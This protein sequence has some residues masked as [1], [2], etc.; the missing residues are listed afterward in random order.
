M[1]CRSSGV[2]I[3]IPFTFKARKCDSRVPRF[4]GLSFG[5]QIMMC[6]TLPFSLP[7]CETVNAFYVGRMSYQLVFMCFT[8]N[9]LSL[10]LIKC[11]YNNI[12]VIILLK[13]QLI[14][15]SCCLRFLQWPCHFK[16]NISLQVEMNNQKSA[17][18]EYKHSDSQLYNI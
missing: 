14:F 1:F 15:K 8:T 17:V 6:S 12:I 4:N 16:I 18:L 2:F 11:A 10:F 3:I 9:C 7:W 13:L 5:V